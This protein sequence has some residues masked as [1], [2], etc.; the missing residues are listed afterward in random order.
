MYINPTSQIHYLQRD[1]VWKGVT[2]PGLDFV[3]KYH[4]GGTNS[5]SYLLS[6]Q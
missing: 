1:I 2:L 6:N 4:K 5:C 3:D